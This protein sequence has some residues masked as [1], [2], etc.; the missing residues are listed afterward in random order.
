MAG[1]RGARSVR[2]WPPPPPARGPRSRAGATARPR[3][4]ILEFVAQIADRVPPEDRVAVFDNDGTLW[5][6]KPMPIQLDF[7]LRRF[8]EMAER[9]SVA[10]RAPAVEGRLRARLR[11][12]RQAHGGALRGRRHERPGAG[13]RHPGRLRR[14]ERRGVRGALGPLPARHAAPDAR[15]R[16]PRVRVRADARA[17]RPPRRQPLQQLHRLGRGPRL[18]A[19]DQPGGLRDP[20]PARD[21]QQRRARLHERRPRRHDHA[22]GGAGLPR[23]RPREARPDLEPHGPPAAAGG[24]QLQRR[25]PDAGVHPARGQADACACS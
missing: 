23:R 25:R 20:A 22:Q 3:H 2:P 11:L 8:V 1:P 24:R 14:D 5:C 6:E 13:R 4:A 12:A 18:H 21:R 9:R 15:P 19:A 7:I 16:L 10:A 17:A